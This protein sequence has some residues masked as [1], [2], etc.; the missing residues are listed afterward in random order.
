MMQDADIT[1]KQC[2]E[3]G[4]SGKALIIMNDEL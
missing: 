1:L 4:I 3:R 2:T